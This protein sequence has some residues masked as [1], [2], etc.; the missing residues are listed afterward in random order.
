VANKKYLDIPDDP[1]DL[2]QAVMACKSPGDYANKLGVPHNCVKFKIDQ[3]L[4]D[5][6]KAQLPSQRQRKPKNG[7]GV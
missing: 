3:M 2:F 1:E 4:N 7:Q 5:E 6:Q